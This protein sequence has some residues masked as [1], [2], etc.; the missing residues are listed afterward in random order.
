MNARTPMPGDFGVT[1]I[2]GP[3]GKLIR[4]GQWLNG[5]GFSDYEHA[6]VYVGAGWIVEAMPG[7]AVKSRLSE[8]DGQHIAWYPSLPVSRFD[9]IRNALGLVGTPYSFADYVALAAV[10][11]RLPFAGLIRRYVAN[12]RHMICSQLVDEAYR[13]AGVYLF[14]DGRAAQDV[15]PGDLYRLILNERIKS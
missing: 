9:I 12:T 8:Y 1:Q 5:D 15:T 7:G 13:R 4:F 3:V 10:R 6:F 11:L 14:T 2:R